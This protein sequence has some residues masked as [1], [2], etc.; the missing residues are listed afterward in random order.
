MIDAL[1]GQIAVLNEERK[2]WQEKADQCNKQEQ[3]VKYQKKVAD[4]EVKIAATNKKVMRWRD[5]LEKI[6]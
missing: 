4:I 3:K 1:D 6:S 5:E 2:I